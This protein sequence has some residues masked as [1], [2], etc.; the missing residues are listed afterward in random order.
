MDAATLSGAKLTTLGMKG[1]GFGVVDRAEVS[2]HPRKK[3][4]CQPWVTSQDGT[5]QVSAPNAP[6]HGSFQHSVLV[7]DAGGHCSRGA[8][9]GKELSHGAMVLKAR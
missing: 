3:E 1:V 2:D 6:R 5:V 4:V 9:A 7:A 8:C